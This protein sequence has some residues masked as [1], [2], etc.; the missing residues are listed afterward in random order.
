MK[1]NKL[2]LALLTA[3]SIFSASYGGALTREEGKGMYSLTYYYY[4][5]NKYYDDNRNKIT[6]PRFHKHELNFYLEYGLKNDLMATFQTAAVYQT[7]SGN[8]AVGI[9]DFEL[10][11]T[12][13]LYYENGNVLSVRGVAIIPGLYN[14]NE[15]P[16]IGLGKFGAEVGVLGGI[17]RNRFYIDNFFGYRYYSGDIGFIRDLFMLGVKLAPQWEYIG[18]LD[19]WYGLNGDPKKRYTISP[20]QR[21]VQFYNTLRYRY[22]DRTSFIFGFSLNLYAENTGSGNHFYVG[23]WQEF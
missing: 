13:R 10:G 20:K 18:V 15:H 11:L 8:S 17:Y 21:F 22:T 1:K 3:T 16:Y 14:P 5:S 12:K 7:Q 6:T 19:L 2:I 23:I 9:G 4:T